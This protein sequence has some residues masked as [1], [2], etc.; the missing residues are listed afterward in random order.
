MFRTAGNI[1]PSVP[2]LLSE[3]AG[4]IAQRF[5]NVQWGVKQAE[6]FLRADNN[7]KMIRD[8][9]PDDIF[10]PQASEEVKQAVSNYTLFGIT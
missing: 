3:S 9:F 1:A 4:P 10:V 8:A 2:Q 5:Q 7:I 6:L